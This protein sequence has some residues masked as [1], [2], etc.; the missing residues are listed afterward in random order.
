MKNTM[1]R[2]VLALTFLGSVALFAAPA[3]ANSIHDEGDFGGGYG[4]IGPSGGPERYAYVRHHTFRPY[5]YGPTY[6]YGYGPRWGGPAYYYGPGM[7]YYDYQAGPGIGFWG[8]GVGV[9]IG[10]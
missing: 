4:I 2:G 8:P 10:Y 9:G 3:V 5:Y 1:K 7:G 6:S